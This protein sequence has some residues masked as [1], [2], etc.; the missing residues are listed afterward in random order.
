MFPRSNRSPVE[1]S[2]TKSLRNARLGGWRKATAVLSVAALALVAAPGLQTAAQAADEKPSIKVALT[3][4]IDS[5]NPFLAVLATGTS[6]LGYQYEGLVANS[7]ESNEVVPA[8]AEKWS[9]SPDGKEWT[10]TLPADGK[11]S[12]GK[13]ITSKDVK[14]TY[15]AVANVDA[16]KQANGSLVENIESVTAPDEKTVVIKL[17]AAQA[18]NPGG[19]LPIVPEHIWAGI[20]DPGKFANDKDAVG[21]GPYTVTSYDKTGGV[22]LKTNPNYRSG[23]AKVAGVIYVPY[24]N[25][26]A[27]VQALKT[28]EVDIVDGLT[29]AQYGALKNAPNI[30]TNAGTGR[31]Y[32]A[33]A[34]N[35]GAKDSSGKDM[36]NG[37]VALHDPVLRQAIVRAIDSKTILEKVRQGL[38]TQGTGIIPAV[39]PTFHWNAKPEDLTLSYDKDAANKLLDDAGYKKGADGIRLDKSGKPL[40][41]R[42]MG[43]STDPTHQ[44]MADFV[45]PWLKEIG[46]NISTEMK[47][48]AQV[49]DESTLGNYDL[50]FTGWGI[51]A[52]PDFQLSI[53]QCSSRPN[54]DGTGATSESNWC[55]PEFDA[56]YKK[57]HEELD[58]A[59]RAQLVIDAQKLIY[60]AAVNN[61]M[62]Y[63]D[64]L[65]AYRSDRFTG[66][67]TQP[68]KNGVI[69]GQTGPWGLYSATPVAA[70][71]DQSQSGGSSATIWWIV[72]GVVVLAAIVVVVLRRKSATSD[73]RE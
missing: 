58:A 24:K 22:K 7:A 25:T 48:P 5:L 50:Y 19:E 70:N 47:A 67:V 46:I 61:V 72:G 38:G 39:Y 30:S 36:G 51:G 69:M 8:I 32:S 60:Q 73:D 59:K 20:S 34:I 45:K 40:N 26:D 21:S 23:A 2:A 42:L 49:N 52:D 3:G 6:I 62:Y 33:I 28:G 44:Q 12:D 14:W 17:K 53:N 9:T 16:L 11:W 41:L 37:N 35:P 29:V 68:A 10:Y 27:A 71:A 43:R 18:P 1:V 13:P 55:S 57:Q 65:E 4:D 31:R 54:A 15:D 56:V 64:A 66:F 63:G